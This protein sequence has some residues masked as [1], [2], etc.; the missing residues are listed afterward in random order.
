MSMPDRIKLGIFT[1][2][3][4]AEKV[5]FELLLNAFEDISEL[6]PTH[7]TLED[8]EDPKTKYSPYNY[9]KILAQV[10]SLYNDEDLPV[11]HRRKDPQY[12]AYLFADDEG[13]K[14]ISIEFSSNLRATDL[15]QIF[16]LGNTLASNLDA[17]LAFVH[18]IWNGSDREYS[19][20]SA[21]KTPDLQYIWVAL[22]L[23][24]YLVWV[25]F[26]KA[27]WTRTFV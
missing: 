2:R 26:S 9:N 27:N 17:E 16:A 7:W 21:I 8:A 10:S 23:C 13:L 12:Q 5:N 18:P 25:T 24:S 3:N 19:A 14:R 11:L 15:P 1:W 20:P 4:L 6:A 22:N